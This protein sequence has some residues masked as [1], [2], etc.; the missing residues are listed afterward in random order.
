MWDA[1]GNVSCSHIA[2]L[3]LVS[4]L[5]FKKGGMREGL[6]RNAATDS[7]EEYLASNQV[8]VGPGYFLNGP[9]GQRKRIIDDIIGNEWVPF[10]CSISTMAT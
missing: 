9:I 1:N 8:G 10:T 5:F 3:L 6:I 4:C 7:F 2:V